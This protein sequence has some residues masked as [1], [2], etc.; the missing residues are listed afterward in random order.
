MYLMLVYFL[1]GK[2]KTLVFVERKRNADFL[3]SWVSQ[4]QYP[5]TS[6]SG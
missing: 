5:A 4:N 1:L 2:D 3:A 6:I